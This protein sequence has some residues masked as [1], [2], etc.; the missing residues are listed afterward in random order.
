MCNVENRTKLNSTI[1]RSNSAK[2]LDPQSQ[3]IVK[4]LKN[5]NKISYKLCFKSKA[6]NETT[7]V[8]RIWHLVEPQVCPGTATTQW[9]T[10]NGQRGE[11]GW[12]GRRRLVAPRCR[13]LDYRAARRPGLGPG[14]RPRA[15]TVTVSPGPDWPGP[16][17]R[18]WPGCK[19]SC[20]VGDTSGGTVCRVHESRHGSAGWAK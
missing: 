18:D 1:P 17:D 4:T 5:Q 16:T 8:R 19:E 3:T 2:F 7:R 6:R 12:Q 15:A 10:H 11:V 9:H 13:G 14:Q 20:S